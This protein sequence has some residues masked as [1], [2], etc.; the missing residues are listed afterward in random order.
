MGSSAI[1]ASSS[2]VAFFLRYHSEMKCAG[3]ANVIPMNIT[4][5]WKSG[6]L[7]ACS[8]PLIFSATDWKSILDEMV[9]PVPAARPMRKTAAAFASH[10]SVP[11]WPAI[12]RLG[13]LVCP[14]R[15][16]IRR[17][18]PAGGAACLVGR[19][20]AVIFLGAGLRCDGSS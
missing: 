2:G 1:C 15:R 20:G 18:T 13:K 4:H 16:T 12:V 3:S 8:S 6:G 14:M 17:K 7:N 11:L 5:V 19:G 9:Q 10:V